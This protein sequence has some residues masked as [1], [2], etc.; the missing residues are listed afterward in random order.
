MSRMNTVWRYARWLLLC[1]PGT[2]PRAPKRNALV[3]LLYLFV[4]ML[5][6]SVLLS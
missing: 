5:V 2:R 6:L 3:V 1:V 4:F